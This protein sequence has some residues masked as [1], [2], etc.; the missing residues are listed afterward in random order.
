MYFSKHSKKENTNILIENNIY[1]IGTDV[2]VLEK[3]THTF[4]KI[5]N[6]IVSKN[7]YK[8][9]YIFDEKDSFKL[10]NSDMDI[11][12]DGCYKIKTSIN[13][14]IKN[15]NV[16]DVNLNN[17]YMYNIKNGII[18]NKCLMGYYIDLHHR[19]INYVNEDG[20]TSSVSD[21]IYYF[22]DTNI[23]KSVNN[24]LKNLD[25]GCYQLTNIINKNIIFESNKD[26]INP[27]DGYFLNKKTLEKYKSN[28]N[29]GTLYNGSNI[30]TEDK[31]YINING[32]LK[33]IKL[34][35]E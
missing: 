10:K 16:H 32:M 8:G 26:G 12:P 27:Y 6:N 34:E 35:N 11:V 24:V 30:I 15:W 17:Y 23:Y 7:L 4:I 5:D 21:G 1:K 9:S 31:I 14:D 19:V 29:I 22:D 2:K 13:I 28:N 33:S 25:I 3:V 20:I 18:L